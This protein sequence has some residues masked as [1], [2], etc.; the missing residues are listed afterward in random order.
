MSAA[1]AAPPRPPPPLTFTASAA[2]PAAELPSPTTPSLS[3]SLSPN[4]SPTLSPTPDEPPPP[5]RPRPG[6]VHLDQAP[7]SLF[8]AKDRPQRETTRRRS[9]FGDG[10]EGGELLTERSATQQLRVGGN[11]ARGTSRATRRFQL[12]M[13]MRQQQQGAAGAATVRA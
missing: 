8:A 5:P 6:E 4:A 7:K 9:T 12:L 11:Q 10:A 2:E 13:H 1:L 3:S